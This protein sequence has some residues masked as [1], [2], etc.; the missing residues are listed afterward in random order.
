MKRGRSGRSELLLTL[1][2]QCAPAA[3]GATGRT[4]S[5]AAARI[6]RAKGCAAR[7]NVHTAGALV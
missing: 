3:S 5:A 1:L 2:L 7:P 4:V 6:V